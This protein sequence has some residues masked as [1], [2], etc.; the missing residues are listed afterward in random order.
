MIV[1]D[2]NV[3]RLAVSNAIERWYPG[4]VISI[5]DLRPASTI[6]DEAVPTCLRRAKEATFVTTNVSDYWNKIQVS[7]AYCVIAIEI[8]NERISEIPELVREI[9]R[10][11]AFKTKASRMGKIIRWTPTRIEY[12]EANRRVIAVPLD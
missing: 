8:A 5:T 1:L 10:L 3:H 6:K 11:D 4:Q 7:P 2:E 9:L 12:Y